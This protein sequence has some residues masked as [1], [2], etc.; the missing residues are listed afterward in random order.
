M[1]S[2]E[3]P[4]KDG[5]LADITLGYDTLGEYIEDS[6][7][8][9]ATVGRYANRIGK[10]KFV[11][12]GIEYKLAANNGENHLHGGIKGFDKVVWR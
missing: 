10:A 4:D 3:V 9:G 12:N 7:Y 11:L 5:N 6:P 1:V 8:F 2:L